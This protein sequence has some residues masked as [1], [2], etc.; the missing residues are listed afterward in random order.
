MR[1]VVWLTSYFASGMVVV[2]VCLL[3][4][5]RLTRGEL[6]VVSIVAIAVT[7]IPLYIWLNRVLS[8]P[9]RYGRDVE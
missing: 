2:A 3:L 4:R 6:Y 1:K 5:D 8:R 7:V 9:N